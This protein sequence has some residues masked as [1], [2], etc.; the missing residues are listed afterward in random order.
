MKTIT[1]KQVVRRVIWLPA[2]CGLATHG[3]LLAPPLWRTVLLVAATI[4]II[5]NAVRIANRWAFT[6]AI[7]KMRPLADID[8]EELFP[9]EVDPY[10]ARAEP[11]MVLAFAMAQVLIAAVA[12]TASMLATAAITRLA[13]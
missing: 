6:E 3:A 7:V 10:Q 5:T 4:T 2:L 1:P 8:D 13:A 12:A 9:E 11:G